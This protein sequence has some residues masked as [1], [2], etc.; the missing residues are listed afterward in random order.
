MKPI[1]LYATKIS[2]NQYMTP[3]GYLMCQDVPIARVGTQ[4]YKGFEIGIQD[5]PNTVFTVHRQPEEVFDQKTIT[6]F[7]LM[8]VTNDHPPEEVNSENIKKYYIGVVMNPRKGDGEFDGYLMADLLIQDQRAIDMI[9]SKQKEQ[10]SCGYECDYAPF[11]DSYQ[12]TNIRG[13]H[14]ALVA[15]GRA[16]D[17]VAI[18]DE[19]IVLEEKDERSTKQMADVNTVNFGKMPRRNQR[20]T[21]WMKSVGLKVLAMDGDVEDIDDAVDTMAEERMEEKAKDAILKDY[22]RLADENSSLAAQV[23]ELKA[24]HEKLQNQLRTFAGQ[25]AEESVHQNAPG[26]EVLSEW[27]E[28]ND[29][30]CDAPVANIDPDNGVAQNYSASSSDDKGPVTPKEKQAWNPIT[31]EGKTTVRGKLG[32]WKEISNDAAYQNMKSMIAALPD[33]EKR[34][35]ACDSLIALMEAKRADDSA[36]KDMVSPVK[37]T[38]SKSGVIRDEAYWKE[39]GEKVKKERFRNKEVK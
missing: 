5:A 19:D 35:S 37:T 13:N 24:S 2:D 39:F 8:P 18:R 27:E 17:K 4:Q 20:V 11:E 26:M 9:K 1:V 23:A 38:D 14:V 16:G 33:P 25:E 7:N 12:Q 31:N 30:A 6:S 22:D 3:Q 21:D 34:K 36:Y 15:R 32:S 29:A 10:L 28:G